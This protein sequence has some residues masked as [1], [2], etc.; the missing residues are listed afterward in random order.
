MSGKQI[1]YTAVVALVVVLAYER[2]G[3]A[4][5]PAG[6]RAGMKLAG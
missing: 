4:A 1:A 6:R 3:H 5:T 2:Y